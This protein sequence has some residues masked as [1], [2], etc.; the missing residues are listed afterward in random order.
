MS[1][2]LPVPQGQRPLAVIPSGEPLIGSSSRDILQSPNFSSDKLARHPELLKAEVAHSMMSRRWVVSMIVLNLQPPARWCRYNDGEWMGVE[3]SDGELE[4]RDLLTKIRLSRETTG[5]GSCFAMLRYFV[6][7]P[8][9]VEFLSNNPTVAEH[10]IEAVC[11]DQE[12]AGSFDEDNDTV[13]YL[14]EDFHPKMFPHINFALEL[15]NKEREAACLLPFPLIPENDAGIGP[16]GWA[17][18][19]RAY[20]SYQPHFLRTDAINAAIEAQ[21]RCLARFDQFLG[22]FLQ[23]TEPW[24]PSEE[25]GVSLEGNTFGQRPGQRGLTE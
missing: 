5:N 1:D 8:E 25:R 3:I 20:I 16:R 18:G 24:L 14:P 6:L 22:G 9:A 17:D 2:L 15:F 13:R 23:G 19:H 7:P 10:L 11:H 21:Y 12:M 4:G